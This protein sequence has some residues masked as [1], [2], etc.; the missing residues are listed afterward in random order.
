MPR[1]LQTSPG[2]TAPSG[3]LDAEL[4]PVSGSLGKLQQENARLKTEMERLRQ[5]DTP[6][7]MTSRSVMWMACGLCGIALLFALAVLFRH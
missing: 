6:P 5:S 4:A 2:R 7:P 3:K 1:P